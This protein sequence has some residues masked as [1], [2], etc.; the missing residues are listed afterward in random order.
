MNNRKLELSDVRN[1]LDFDPIT[2]ILTWKKSSYGGFKKSVLVHREGDVAGCK[3]KSDG[4][5]VVRI[6]N[7]LMLAYRLGWWMHTGQMPT[8]EIDHI[9]GDPTDNRICNLRLVS[10]KTNQE[11]IRKPYSHKESCGVLGVYLDNRKAIKKWRAAITTN[12]KQISLG[13]FSTVEDASDA[14]VTAKRK[15]HSGCTI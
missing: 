3:R 12:G 15:L 10:R 4:R 2:G 1:Q 14:Y 9:N 13:Y 6:N 11:N 7:K 8:G 5:I